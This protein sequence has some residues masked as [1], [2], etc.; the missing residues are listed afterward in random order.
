MQEAG[1][2]KAHLEKGKDALHLWSQVVQVVQVQVQV[3]QVRIV[4]SSIPSGATSTTSNVQRRTWLPPPGGKVSRRKRGSEPAGRENS[5]LDYGYNDNEDDDGN[6]DND[7]ADDD[8]D[9]DDDLELIENLCA[10]LIVHRE[11][12]VLIAEEPESRS[13]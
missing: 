9:E 11:Q 6:G 13:E 5:T 2:A 10:R 3:V 4:I 12:V 7:D 8:D 1:K